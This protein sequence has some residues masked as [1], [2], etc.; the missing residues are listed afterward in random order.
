MAIFRKGVKIANQDIRV[1]VGKKRAQGL[2]R[3]AGIIDDGKGLGAHARNA[4]GEVNAIRSV[5]ARG[6][7]FQMPVNFKVEFSQPVGISQQTH[8]TGS[9][10]SSGGYVGE[11]KGKVQSGTLDWK[12]HIMNNSSFQLM[13]AR[14]DAANVSAKSMWKKTKDESKGSVL[15]PNK[16]PKAAPET[17]RLV[18]KMDLY[19][20]KISIPSKSISV[21]YQKHYGAPFPWPQNVQYGTLTT[22]FYCDG[23]MHIKNY[24]DAWQKLINND[25][26]GNMNYYDEY[27]SEFNVFARTTMAKGV[28]ETKPA[29]Q[30][31]FAA[32][33][34]GAI[35]KVREATAAFNAATGFDTPRDGKQGANIQPTTVFRESYGAKIFDC[36]PSEVGQ[37]DFGHDMTDSIATFDVTWAY[38]KWS[39]FKMGDVGNRGKIN[40]AIG[41]FR[42]EKGGL[43]FISELPPELSGPLTNAV[44]QG[45]VTGPLSKASN[46][47]G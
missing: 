1:S 30:S 31:A 8:D 5:V 17:E 35:G 29:E 28:K 9:P 46:L 19:C 40:L 11:N 16:N 3:K 41:E 38:R 12:T 26:T 10:H 42:N 47:L 15:F 32:A 36:F 18:A 37:I 33:V 27:T 44:N 14:F 43:P 24:F 7:G 25:I 39:P 2:L 13:K 21:A 4:D 23:A 45:V 22:T 20:S 6:E 34:N